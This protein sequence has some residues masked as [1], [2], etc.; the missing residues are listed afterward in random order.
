MWS[1]YQNCKWYLTQAT[2]WDRQRTSW[3]WITKNVEK[4][5]SW[6]FELGI[7]EKLEESTIKKK[8]NG[9]ISCLFYFIFFCRKW[10]MGK[11]MGWRSNDGQW[12]WARDTNNQFWDCCLSYSRSMQIFQNN[13]RYT[14]LKLQ[15]SIS[16]VTN[17]I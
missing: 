5:T 14:R 6:V 4:L 11:M 13:F 2:I 16:K 7:G 8:N 10:T 17:F 3:W 9:R 15:K 12:N 1:H